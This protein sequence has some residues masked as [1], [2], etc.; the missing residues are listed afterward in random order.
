MLALKG[1]PAKLNESTGIFRKLLEDTGDSKLPGQGRDINN[2]LPIVSDNYYLGV[3]LV[4]IAGLL[5]I[6]PDLLSGRWRRWRTWEGVRQAAIARR[7][8][9]EKGLRWGALLLTC[10]GIFI[11]LH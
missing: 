11:A 3:A 6:L 8:S 1:T 9:F 4:G 2:R 5:W 10:A 7:T